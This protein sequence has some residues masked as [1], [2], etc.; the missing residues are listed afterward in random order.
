MGWINIIIL[1]L[2][3]GPTIIGLIKELMDALKGSPEPKMRNLAGDVERVAM[4]FRKRRD[5]KALQHDLRTLID[6]VKKNQL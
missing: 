4:D 6:R 5:K 2:R 1:L 3:Y